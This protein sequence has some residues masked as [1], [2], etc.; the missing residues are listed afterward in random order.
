VH[1]SGASHI[2]T[3]H[4]HSR[5]QHTLG[6]FA[7]VAHFCPEDTPLRVAALLHDVGHLPFSHSLEQLEGINHHSLT[8][9]RIVTPPIWD[10]L[11]Q[12]GMDP[13]IVLAI[14]E[15]TL[16]NPLCNKGN[17]L[18]IDHLDSF[19]RNAQVRGALPMSTTHILSRTKLQNTN[20][21]VSHEVAETLVQL[22]V[23]EARFV[24]SSANLGPS[25]ILKHLVEELLSNNVL[26]IYDLSEMTDS[27][28]ERTLF[29]HPITAYRARRLWYQP[30]TIVVERL[31]TPEAPS[32]DLIA[33]VNKLYLSVPLV[34]GKPITS[35]SPRVSGLLDQA[36]K[37]HGK[38]IVRWTNE[39]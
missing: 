5:L 35:F 37:L 6:V 4:T 28:V 8:R 38:Y 20:I 29:E 25:T 39:K 19:V 10:I 3:Q 11:V 17:V 21:E 22:V 33:H 26:T 2:N 31:N 14:L 12:N 18:S 32:R 13:E 7:L 9:E 24:S 34:D 30:S 27:A 1:H 16:S 36:R 15:S 23:D